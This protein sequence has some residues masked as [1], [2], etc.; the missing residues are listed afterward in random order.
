MP[1]TGTASLPLHGGRAPRWLFD[2]MVRLAEAIADVMTYEYGR[3]RFLHLLADPFW[4]QALSCVLGFDWHSSG[5]TTVTCG[6]LKEALGPQHGMCMAGGK[7][8]RSRDTQEELFTLGSRFNLRSD[9]IQDVQYASRMAA[10]VDNAAV[11]D[12]YDLYHHVAVVTEDGDWAV[13]QQGMN[14]DAGYARRYH[15][16]SD[17]LQDFVCEPHLSVVGKRGPTLNLTARESGAAR[18]V[19]VDVVND[20]PRHL[21]RDWARLTIPPT[22]TTLEGERG[23]GQPHL[24]MPRIINWNL[25]Q[26]IYNFQP[27]TYEEL[28]SFPGVGPATVRA[29]AYISEL[30]HGAPSSWKDPTKFSFAVGGK[31]GVPYPV[32]RRAM[33]EATE[34]IKQGIQEARV[35]QRDRLRAIKR[36][37]RLVPA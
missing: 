22:Q 21:L 25:L 5:T 6:A 29:L 26:G 7:G 14:T 3:Q 9:V 37:K 17:G 16:L 32:N 11:Q 18:R 34:L 2:R 12:G 8:A 30:L 4:F 19:A 1:R 33:D 31:D 13:I 24:H 23:R 20:G 27:R 10:K 28:L 15:W 35:G 36:L